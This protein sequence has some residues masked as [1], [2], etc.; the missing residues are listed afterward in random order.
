MSHPKDSRPGWTLGNLISWVASLPMVGGLELYDLKGSFQPKVF[1]DYMILWK[2]V[3][4]PTD[5]FSSLLVRPISQYTNLICWFPALHLF[6]KLGLNTVF[7]WHA[8]TLYLDIDDLSLALADIWTI[9]GISLSQSYLLWVMLSL[10]LYRNTF[11]LPPWSRKPSERWG[12]IFYLKIWNIY[13]NPTWSRNYIREQK[14]HSKSTLKLL[15]NICSIRKQT[16]H[17][18]VVVLRINLN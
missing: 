2:Y 14:R 4:G 3:V 11:Y 6:T 15:Q 10:D 9:S 13:R 8:Q 1:C 7:D 16:V 5:S 18:L 17:N 12:I